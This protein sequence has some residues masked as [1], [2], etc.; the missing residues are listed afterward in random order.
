MS[1]P[2]TLQTAGTL[3]PPATTTG[4]LTTL[5]AALVEQFRCLLPLYRLHNLPHVGDNHRF[6][7]ALPVR[8]RVRRVVSVVL[9]AHAGEELDACGDY[10]LGLDLAVGLVLFVYSTR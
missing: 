6:H 7:F 1:T 4:A 8:L 3:R 2:T 10:L 9:L 5:A